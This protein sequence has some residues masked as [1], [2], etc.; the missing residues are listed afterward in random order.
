MAR[1]HIFTFAE[2]LNGVR[3]QQGL[4]ENGAFQVL[5]LED[6]VGEVRA[7]QVG[8]GK[9]GGIKVGFHGI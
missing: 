5:R 7:F 9:I 3:G 4:S 1:E 6:R 2:L 8:L